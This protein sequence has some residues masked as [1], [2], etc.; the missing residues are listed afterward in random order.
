MKKIEVQTPWTIIRTLG[1]LVLVLGAVV[2]LIGQLQMELEMMTQLDQQY[3]LWSRALMWLVGCGLFAVCLWQ[4]GLTIPL[5][6]DET[7]PNP[8][9]LFRELC[10]LHALDESEVQLL[11]KLALRAKVQEPS[12]LF[13][14]AR[15]WGAATEEEK[16]L[17]SKLFGA[18]INASPRG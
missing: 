9:R 13:V 12:L 7:Y 8:V 17:M 4:V 5:W 6:L 18:S 15:V 3:D 2:F 16:P 11:S 1:T 14:D 10:A